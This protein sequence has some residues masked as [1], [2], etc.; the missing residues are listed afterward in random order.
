[1][2]LR[3]ATRSS[4]LALWQAETAADHLR[5]AWSD[6]RVE[7]VHVQSSGE[8]HPDR[9]LARFGRIG[10]FTAEVDRAVFEG[11]ADAGVH[12]LKDMTTELVDG[13]ALAAVMARGPVEDVLVSREG[14]RLDELPQG[15]RIATGSLRRAAMVRALRADVEIVGMRGNVQT[16][17]RKLDEGEADAMVMARAGLER[18][19]L[20]DRIAEVLD[21]GRFLP[22]VGQGIVG[23]TC[24]S[25]ADETLRRL[26]AIRDLEAWDEA[27]AERALLAA[28]RGGCNV[29]LGAHARAVEGALTMRARVLSIDGT[30]A[31]EGE[32]HG[33][34]DD[35]VG[36]GER[37]AAHLL[38]RGAGRLVEAARS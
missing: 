15:A 32:D 33:A 14:K 30:E 12:S 2:K 24:R 26:A 17:L 36:I 23:I 7:L 19:G 35:V 29:P 5:S 28:M 11:E 18:V 10:I 21:T 16:R 31:I 13:M 8:A 27:H 25:D 4:P 34:R 9:E 6:V 3:L 22:A 1:M 20:A 37:L 38:E